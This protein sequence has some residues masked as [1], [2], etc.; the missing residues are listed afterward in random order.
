MRSGKAENKVMT[1]LKID[2]SGA[3]TFVGSIG[4]KR[5]QCA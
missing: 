1:Q 2:D 3:Y 4:E 5:M